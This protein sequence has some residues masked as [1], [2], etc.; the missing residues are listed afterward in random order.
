MPRLARA[1]VPGIPHHACLSRPRRRQVTQRGNRRMPTFLRDEDY[2]TY[3]DLMAEWCEERGVEVWAYCLMPAC[4][5]PHLSASARDRQAQ[6]G[7]TTCI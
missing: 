4:C 3:V 6:T 5:V 7:P 2:V 1:L